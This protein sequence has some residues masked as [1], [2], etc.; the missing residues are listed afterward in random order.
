MDMRM[1]TTLPGHILAALVMTGWGTTF[2]GTKVLLRSFS[3]TEIILLRFLISYLTLWVIRPKRIRLTGWKQELPYIIAGTMGVT[4]YYL[5][6]NVALTFTMAS[7]VGIIV[8]TAPFFTAILARM[9]Y[10]DEEKA[11]WHFYL[12]CGIS[13]VGIIVIS[14]NGA[15]LNMNPL[16]DLLTVGAAMSWAFYSLAL[17]KIHNYGYD[18]ILN[19]RRIFFWGLVTSVPICLLTG[20]HPAVEEILK[21][22]NLAILLALGIG[23]GA[24]CYVLWNMASGILGPVRVNVYIYLD[25]VVA[26]AASAMVLHEPITLKAILGTILILGGLII[27][28]FHSDQNRK[29]LSDG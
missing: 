16:G 17:K 26:V 27:S 21:P 1:R 9:I 25:P 7:N 8:A 14:I 4:C 18:D 20:F 19:S 29:D 3:P 28:E 13:F 2:I 5:L 22:L 6:E 12:G 15:Q 23:A 10:G 11:G 24:I